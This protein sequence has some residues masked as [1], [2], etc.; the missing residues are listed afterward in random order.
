VKVRRNQRRVLADDAEVIETGE[1]ELLVHEVFPFG[2]HEQCIVI[3][4]FL[5]HRRDRF[6]ASIVR[7]SLGHVHDGRVVVVVV[8]IPICGRGGC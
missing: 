6:R 5:E 2:K 7:A 8:S 1:S 4:E 3:S